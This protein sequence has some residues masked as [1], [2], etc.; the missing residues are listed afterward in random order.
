MSPASPAWTVIGVLLAL[1]AVALLYRRSRPG[2]GQHGEG[3]AYRWLAAAAAA[4]GAAFAV[5]VAG[6]GSVTPTAIQLSLTDLLALLGLPPLVM[7]LIRLAPPDDSG[8][9]FD[10]LAD[11]AL[12]SLGI[13][14]MAWIAILRPAYASVAVG[15]GSFAVDLVHPLADLVVLGG[16]LAV[17]LRAGRAALAPYLAVVAA[18]LGDLLAVQARAV[19][20]HAGAWPQLAWLLA[21]CLLGA[22][23]VAPAS[24]A[25]ADLR[26]AAGLPAG[27]TTGREPASLGRLSSAAP[28]STAIGL[29]AAGIAAIV[30]L[31]FA[32]VTWGHSGPV[33][34]IAGC[35]LTLALASRAGGLLL[36][37]EALTRLATA[38]G[39]TFHQLADRTSD[40]VLLCD[41]AGLVTYASQAVSHY[42]YVPGQLTG[43]RLTNLVHPDDRLNGIKAAATAMFGGSATPA[44]LSC[45]V[46]A[47]DG[48]WRHVQVTLCRYAG[49]SRPDVVLLTARD[50]SDQVALR[51]QVTHLTFHDGLT[52]LP[53][54]AYLEER[55]K[56]LLTRQATSA[57][58]DRAAAIFVDLDG[59]TAINDSVGHGAGDLLLAQAGRRLRGLVPA[60][61]TV[62][63]WGGDEFAILVEQPASP[64]ETVEIAERLAGAIAAAPFH[65]ADRDITMTASLGVAFTDPDAG[66]HLLRNADLAMAMAKEAGGDRVEVFAAHMHADV[67]R[68]LELATDLRAAIAGGSLDI[69]YQPVVELATSRVVGVE[70][71][72]RWTR[73]GQPVPTTEFLSIAEESGLIIGLGD[74]VLRE[75]CQQAAAWRA[76]GWPVG[77][78][79]NFSLRQV[80]AQRFA[81]SVLTALDDCGLPRSALTLEVTERVLIE[82]AEPMIDELARLRRLGVRLA[83]DDFGTGYASLAYLRAL[84]VD[85]IKIDPSFVA[86]LGTDGTLAMLTRTIVQVGHDLGIEIVAEGIERPEQLELLRAMGCGLGQGYLVARPTPAE[87]LEALSPQYTVK[88]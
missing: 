55:A 24:A 12:L 39:K 63:R 18:T 80:S 75:A 83:I 82:S 33:P 57:G 52:G 36:Q 67:V 7:G 43:L 76:S 81:E 61:D 77:L 74:W 9:A 34:L 2:G 78:S 10:R 70:A 30:T 23:G 16:T 31:I 60:H 79:V 40:V 38:S 64:Q 28:P 32:V 42:G 53:N 5:Q 15:G 11:G 73:N 45:R 59:F 22:A 25:T 71:L 3:A 88:L 8:D 56:D 27:G 13:F 54:R 84:P 47:A 20:A 29:T 68:R 35:A 46:R 6:V 44:S 19:G 17:A 26:G 4:W 41:G 69:E 51:R 72:V 14:A 65:I 62:A 49:S 86:G 50:V 85:I 37:T 87:G 1:G 21:I 58:S 66:E 48:T